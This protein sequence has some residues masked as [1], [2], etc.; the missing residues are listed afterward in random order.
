MICTFQKLVW[1]IWFHFM[2]E[3][4]P[5]VVVFEAQCRI[6]LWTTCILGQVFEKWHR[7]GHKT[8]IFRIVFFSRILS[9]GLWHL[10]TKLETRCGHQLIFLCLLLKN[11]I[12]L[13][14]KDDIALFRVS[15]LF[16]NSICL[17]AIGPWKRAFWSDRA[18]FKGP[19]PR[20][21]HCFRNS[22]VKRTP[23]GV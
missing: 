4:I 15:L 2:N 16:S 17:E 21:V 22:R 18:P 13:I 23:H 7:D 19:Q 14:I 20:L 8:F 3:N 11:W 6:R 5:K 10:L 1:S 12:L 9:H